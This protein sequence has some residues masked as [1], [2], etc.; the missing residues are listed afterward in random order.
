MD[1]PSSMDLDVRI[2]NIR[3]PKEINKQIE[4]N[5]DSHVTVKTLE[6]PSNISSLVLKD[7]ANIINAPYEFPDGEELISCMERRGISVFLNHFSYEEGEL[8]LIENL[9][10]LVSDYRTKLIKNIP[11]RY[12]VRDLYK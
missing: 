8:Q 7:G 4:D 1:F 10:S 12:F 2:I 6:D 3:L 11:E 5:F 9:K